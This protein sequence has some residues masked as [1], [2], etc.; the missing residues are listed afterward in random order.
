VNEAAGN[1]KGDLRRSIPLSE[2]ASTKPKDDLAIEPY[3]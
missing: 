3:C 2:K 1:Q